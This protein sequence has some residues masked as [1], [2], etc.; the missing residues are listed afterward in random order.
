LGL[1]YR[2][3]AIVVDIGGVG[4]GVGVGVEWEL[5]DRGRRDRGCGRG[6]RERRRRGRE[7]V[8]LEEWPLGKGRP[9]GFRGW[10]VGGNGGSG[11]FGLGC[12]R[13]FGRVVSRR[14]IAAGVA[15]GGS[16]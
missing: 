11:V 16:A 1:G 12:C 3:G 7:L 5:G 4:V 6:G 13:L 10:R 15:V 2:W 8:P 9:G 14:L